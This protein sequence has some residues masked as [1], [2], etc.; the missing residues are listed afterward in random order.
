MT[1]NATANLADFMGF[2][3]LRLTLHRDPRGRI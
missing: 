3:R 1:A 2:L